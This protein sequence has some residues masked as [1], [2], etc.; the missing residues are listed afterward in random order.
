MENQKG[1]TKDELIG[2]HGPQITRVCILVVSATQVFAAVERLV[3]KGI[4]APRLIF[5]IFFSACVG[6][7]VAALIAAHEKK[8]AAAEKLVE[9]STEIEN[10]DTKKNEK[11]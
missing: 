3:E 11:E 7:M 8:K 1:P 6:F 5:L 10:E 9:A 2:D 4:N